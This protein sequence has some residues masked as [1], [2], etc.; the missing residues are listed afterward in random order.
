MPPIV[1]ALESC[2]GGGK[3]FLLKN[4]AA[5]GL[6]PP[7]ANKKV[8]VMFQ[9]DHIENV[10][11]AAA[12]ATRWTLCKE[13]GCLLDHV[14]MFEGIDPSADLVVVEGS[15]ASDRLCYFLE[16][17]RDERERALYETWYALLEQRWRVDAHVLLD[18]SAY[19]IL[20]RIVSNSKKEQ[21]GTSLEGVA[22]AADLYRRAFFGDGR[23]VVRAP[24][25]FED[26]EPAMEALKRRLAEIAFGLKH[27]ANKK[28]QP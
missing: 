28:E 27:E 6:G 26:N 13:L 18:Q 2:F 5:S 8:Q 15:P 3:G 16:Q 19:C 14:R 25:H 10:I 24:D 23:R 22:R 17:C 1:V 20:E 21:G 9:D 4:V 7:W 11:D 12:D